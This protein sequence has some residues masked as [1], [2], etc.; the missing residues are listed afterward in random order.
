MVKIR[1]NNDDIFYNLAYFRRISENVIEISGNIPAK[2]NGFKAYKLETNELLGDY[3]DFNTIYSAKGSVIRYSNDGSIEPTKDAVFKVIWIN[4]LPSKRPA[5]TNITISENGVHKTYKVTS[6]DSWEKAFKIPESIDYTLIDAS[7]HE[8]YEKVIHGN[9][10]EY[11]Y[12][13]IDP[14]PSEIQRI[15]DLE[16]AVCELY[17]LIGQNN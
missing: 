4:D 3:S 17:E 14:V 5:F 2:S 13:K 15:A 16:S 12:E 10:V 6:D 1:F 7:N 8:S 11:T 9:N